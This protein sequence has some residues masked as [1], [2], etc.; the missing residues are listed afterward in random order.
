MA[1]ECLRRAA[2]GPAALRFQSIARAC[3]DRRL[4]LG[5]DR[6]QLETRAFLPRRKFDRGLGELRHLRPHVDKA[7]ALVRKPI[8]ESQ[9]AFVAAWQVRALEGIEPYV[10]EDWPVDLDRGTEPPAR[11][12]GEAIFVV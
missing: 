8:V 1:T 11:L 7:P 2:R 6:L 4:D 5:F 9:G 3:L 10:C 12:I